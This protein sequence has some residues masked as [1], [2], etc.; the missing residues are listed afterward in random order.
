MALPASSSRPPS[1]DRPGLG[2]LCLIGVTLIF[3]VQDALTKHL[4]SLYPVSFIVMVRYWIF[5]V[6]A[7]GLA[8]WQGGR[9]GGGI[10]GALVSQRPLLQALR[11][12]LLVGEIA[13]M[14]VAF[15][16]LGLAEV[17]AVFAIY[18]L[19]VMVLAIP[20]LGEHVGWHRWMA[21]GV[22]FAGLLIVVRPGAG[23]FEPAALAAASAALL[24]ALFNVLSR[25]L[26]RVDS[27][28]TTQLYTAGVGA[29][30]ITVVGL[31]QWTPLPGADW[32][33]LGIMSALSIAAHVLLLVALTLTQASVLQPYNYLMLVWSIGV[34]Y[35]VFHDIPDAWTLT[36]GAVIVASGLYALHRQRLSGPGQERR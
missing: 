28:A 5:A 33:A 30:A 2:I 17:Q 6:F 24:Y 32:V 22:A 4:V 8:L 25:S 12:L 13:L 27:A 1:T 10:R 11:G 9:Q 31:G 3:A 21:T 26:S 20:I 34:G 16:S 36:G 15:R 14:A 7:V 29:A 19:L 18:P 35:V 23:T